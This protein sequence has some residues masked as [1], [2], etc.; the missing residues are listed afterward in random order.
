M[1]VVHVPL[2]LPPLTQ[3]EAV[4]A[5]STRSSPSKISQANIAR[6][7][8]RDPSPGQMPNLNTQSGVPSIPVSQ[9]STTQ[10]CGWADGNASGCQWLSASPT[11]PTRAPT[12]IHVTPVPR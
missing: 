1:G 8:F 12:T 4:A 3:A 2:A 10:H 5:R 11:A 7:T 6:S 9:H